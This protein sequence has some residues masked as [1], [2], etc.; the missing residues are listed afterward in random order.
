MGYQDH[1]HLADDVITHLDEVIG[2]LDDEF[3]SS[4]Y[5]GLVA[6]A[7][8]TVYELSIKDIF[9]EFG[10]AKN[11]VFG[12]FTR[13]HFERINGRIKTRIIKNEYIKRF[14]D[15]YVKRFSR[16][17]EAIEKSYLRTHNISIR[18]SYNNI[19]EWRN[20]FAHA[21]TLPM[22]V[23][24]QEVIDSYEYGKLVIECLAETMRR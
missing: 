22:T 13:S 12:N 19:I 10:E 5:I 6:I 9:C 15:K 11:K 24:Y 1:F 17:I 23:T 16:K 20:Q 4:R 18:S 7:A 2:S 21:G 3:I 8:V 14:G